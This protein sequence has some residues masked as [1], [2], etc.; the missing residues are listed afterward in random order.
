MLVL[1]AKLNTTGSRAQ[2]DVS[3]NTSHRLKWLRHVIR[4]QDDRRAKK[5]FNTWQLQ[6]KQR[7]ERP[8]KDTVTC[9][10]QYNGHLM[11]TQAINRNE[12]W[13]WLLYMCHKLVIIIIIIYSFNK[14]LTSVT[15]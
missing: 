4:L 7:Y 12:W 1:A 2:E 6:E 10:V 13:S 9:D 15:Y 5:T 3:T 8:V 11:G 14:K